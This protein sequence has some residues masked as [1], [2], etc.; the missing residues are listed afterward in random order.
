[1]PL[2]DNN[3]EPRYRRGEILYIDQPGR[4]CRYGDDVVVISQDGER[5]ETV[6][7]MLATTGQD[8]TLIETPNGRFISI[9]TASIRSLRRISFTER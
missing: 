3:L 7:G 8:V 5:A 1:M 2:T 4:E 9:P 6:I